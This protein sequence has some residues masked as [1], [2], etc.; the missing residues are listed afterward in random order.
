MPTSCDKHLSFFMPLRLR[1]FTIC[2]GDAFH[3]LP[4]Q[5]SEEEDDGAE[6]EDEQKICYR[7]EREQ[8]VIHSN[9][10]STLFSSARP[11]KQHI[12]QPTPERRLCNQ[13]FSLRQ[14]AG[15]SHCQPIRMEG[16]RK[17][18]DRRGREG[19]LAC[20]LTEHIIWGQSFTDEFLLRWQAAALLNNSPRSWIVWADATIIEIN[21]INETMP[22][23][24]L[25]Q[26]EMLRSTT[27]EEPSDHAASDCQLPF[28]QRAPGAVRNEYAKVHP[29]L[30]S[31]VQ[32]LWKRKCIF[33]QHFKK[34]HQLPNH[35]LAKAC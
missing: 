26:S 15:C 10:S 18:E 27:E 28:S 29:T 5:A 32:F 25:I 35:A 9:A 11:G 16:E 34:Q 1:D 22:R 20:S 17:R 24:L 30:P 23:S 7:G 21:G 12:L 14:A 4:W 3:P 19:S 33:N 13:E 2:Q 8:L 6:S 31:H